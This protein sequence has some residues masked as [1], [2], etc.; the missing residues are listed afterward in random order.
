MNVHVVRRD[1]VH[2]IALP[3][4]PK[5]WVR[6]WGGLDLQNPLTAQLW[7]LLEPEQSQGE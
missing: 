3:S 2:T 6:E 4:L 1:L 7:H 5:G